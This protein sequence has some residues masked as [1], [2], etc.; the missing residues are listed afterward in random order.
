M[1]VAFII[2][3]AFL[4]APL[5]AAFGALALQA[6]SSV[7]LD[8]AVIIS[9]LSRLATMPL[10]QTLPMFALAG[11]VL[12]HSKA[13]SRLVRVSRAFFGWMPGGLAIV[14]IVAC[15]LFTAFTGATGV[16]IIAL[17]GLLLPALLSERY[18][19]RFA[20]GLVTNGGNV[21]VLF[22]PSLP[23]I[24]YG[25]IANP[26]AREVTIDRLFLAGILPGLLSVGT[27]ALFSALY[28]L[29][30]HVPRTKFS[31]REVLAA[32]WAARW[33][34]PLPFVVIGGIYAGKLVVS[35]A[36]VITAAYAIIVE[37]FFYR[38]VRIRTLGRIVR[39]S[40]VLVGGILIILG[41][42]MAL[43]NYLIDA[44]VPMKILEFTQAHVNSRVVFLL[45]LNLLLL[46]VGCAMDIYTAIIVVVPLILPMAIG[47]GVDP[48]HLGIIFLANM[49]I[50]Y[51]TPP[52]GV[53][54][55]VAS[56]RFN[57]P[58][59]SLYK[60]SVAFLAI[61]FVTLMIITYV[62]AISLWLAGK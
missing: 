15:T 21:G 29:G 9:E 11:Y 48:I 45:V 34:V 53:N 10:L 39:E 5:F 26:I 19:E 12:A 52:V 41:M 40:M 23:L 20:L 32:L 16:T 56:M 50:G 49:A 57:K 17:G 25:V 30:A 22:A 46:V 33:E 14:S 28:G 31:V 1:M 59:V 35:E 7:D 47:F 38:E 51:C 55:F 36:A 58:I 44:E 8:A 2:I 37:V 18:K 4:G 27:L 6:Y 24:L 62:P 3:M 60:A 13:S 54:L 61:Q 43:T 42:G